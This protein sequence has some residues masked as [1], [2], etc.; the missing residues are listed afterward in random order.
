MMFLKN[1]ITFLQLFFFGFLACS[2]L[3][4]GQIGLSPTPTLTPWDSYPELAEGDV[5][6]ATGSMQ[7]WFEYIVYY[8]DADGGSPEIKRLYINGVGKEM[9][10]KSGRSSDGFYSYYINGTHLNLDDNDFF[11][12][13]R[14]DEGNN[15][16]LP[17]SRGYFSGPVVY[18]IQTPT[19]NP[20]ETQII[21]TQGPTQ[22]PAALITS[23]PTITITPTVSPTPEPNIQWLPFWR[24]TK[25]PEGD[26]FF[27][28]GNPSGESIE[29]EINLFNPDFRKLRYES[30]I[31][32]PNEMKAFFAGDMI[33]ILRGAESDG[34]EQ[35]GFAEIHWEGN[36]PSVFGAYFQE[37]DLKGYPILPSALLLSPVK[38]PYWQVV[39]GT[40]D[41]F[42]YITN[43]SI[44]FTDLRINLYDEGGKLV[45]TILETID[46]SKMSRI[47]L[48]D[49]VDKPASGVAEL[50][51]SEDIGLILHAMVCNLASDTGYPVLIE[52]E[53]GEFGTRVLYLPFFQVDKDYGLGSL[54]ALSSSLL[55]AS[56]SFFLDLFTSG[57]LSSFTGAFQVS[58][59]ELLVLK[60]SD[61]VGTA[62]GNARL[63]WEGH[64]SDI[65][66]ALYKSSNK[67]GYPLNPGKPLDSPATL[68]FW[69]VDEG[70]K[71]NTYLVLQNCSSVEKVAP[72]ITFYNDKGLQ[73]GIVYPDIS[74]D[75]N[76]I[77]NVGKN[78]GEG[79]GTAVIEWE[80]APLNAWGIVYNSKTGAGVPI[81]IEN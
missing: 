35:S 55:D 73:V 4:F 59:R 56:V 41:T 51:W 1:E 47:F 28:F 42:L 58:G 10:L 49:Y 79:T 25:K 71:I 26:T 61:Y 21:I 78:T 32:S 70:S 64:P 19:P 31:L 38:L 34:D 48:S 15:V 30:Y 6:P 52:N 76:K 54:L 16:R 33:D 74:T 14:D 72:F 60:L 40:L 11:F 22:T 44:F 66:S 20:T 43:P 46:A 62:I 9:C 18:M 29:L 67:T 68:P 36:K 3:A 13:F 75:E 5:I 12:F 45:G 57:G 69:Q 63:T 39:P 50:R 24:V 27:A 80:D 65:F 77:I 2:G 17:P 53:G 37:G 23:T 7:S 81:L 8:K